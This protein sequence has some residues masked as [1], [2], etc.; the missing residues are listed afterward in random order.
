MRCRREAMEVSGPVLFSFLPVSEQWQED[1]P[2]ALPKLRPPSLP[3][4]AC[5]TSTRVPGAHLTPLSLGRVQ[6]HPHST[7]AGSAALS[8]SFPS[9]AG[10]TLLRTPPS[11]P[12]YRLPLSSS[13]SAW[14]MRGL[15]NVQGPNCQWD[16]RDP[17][18]GDLI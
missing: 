16:H 4:A 10:H 15:G 9:L 6:G 13:G 8:Y 2:W 12:P 17:L 11:T 18:G 7:S 1:W 5:T 14:Q 3:C